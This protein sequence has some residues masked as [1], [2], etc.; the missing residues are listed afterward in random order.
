VWEKRARTAA[1]AVTRRHLCRR[2]AMKFREFNVVAVLRLSRALHM[3]AA[4]HIHIAKVGDSALR[5]TRNT[6]N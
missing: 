2:T 5:L 6:R 3:H 1:A 4:T